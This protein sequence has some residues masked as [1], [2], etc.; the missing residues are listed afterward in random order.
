[1]E[2]RPAGKFF[3]RRK[4]GILVVNL[5]KGNL[6]PGCSN[7]S[8]AFSLTI[9]RLP[10]LFAFRAHRFKLILDWDRLLLNYQNLRLLLL[11]ALIVEKV[12]NVEICHERERLEASRLRMNPLVTLKGMPNHD[13]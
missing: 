5:S 10:L 13:L 11:G 1:M 12:A 8:V 2:E 4:L 9:H 3:Q 7:L 6:N